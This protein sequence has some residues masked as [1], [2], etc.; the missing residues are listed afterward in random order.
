MLLNPRILSKTHPAGNKVVFPNL[1]GYGLRG[2]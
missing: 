2:I 1:G